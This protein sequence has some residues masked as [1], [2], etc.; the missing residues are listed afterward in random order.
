MFRGKTDAGRPFEGTLRI[1]RTPRGLEVVGIVDVEGIGRQTLRLPLLSGQRPDSFAIREVAPARGVVGRLRRKALAARERL[2]L[3]PVYLE[4]K[5]SPVQVPPGR[6]APAR[7]LPDWPLGAGLPVSNPSLDSGVE[8]PFGAD[9]EVSLRIVPDVLEAVE[10]HDM[11]T[12]FVIEVDGGVPYG[13]EW[14]L[15]APP[16][17]G[18]DPDAPGWNVLGGQGGRRLLVERARWFA[19]PDDNRKLITGADCRCT[20]EVHCAVTVR[21]ERYEALPARLTVQVRPLSGAGFFGKTMNPQYAGQETLEL[22]T[23]TVGET[24]FWVVV[25]R[26]S[27]RRSQPRARVYLSRRSQFYAKTERHEN[28]HVDQ[29]LN[30]GPWMDLYDADALYARLRRL[31]ASSQE[32]LW[33]RLRNRINFQKNRDLSA[34]EAAMLDAEKGAYRAERAIEPHYLELTDSDVEAWY[35]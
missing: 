8:A 9:G 14:R 32:A 11:T 6:Q 13:I 4:R 5:L 35:R 19:D 20:Y 23:R 29:W 18:N 15:L 12:P 28:E 7:E 30:Q 24:A 22:G 27:F 10:G 2:E 21:G 16:G 31:S 17:A 3:V 25:G 34:Q 33:R 26:G 1:R